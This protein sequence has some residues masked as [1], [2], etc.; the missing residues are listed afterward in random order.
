MSKPSE[1]TTVWRAP[2]PDRPDISALWTLVTFDPAEEPVLYAAPLGSPHPVA[3]QPLP[4][5][6][7]RASTLLW[8][9]LPAPEVVDE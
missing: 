8:T 4:P 5:S 2:I 9:L 1:I 3:G 6:W 7:M